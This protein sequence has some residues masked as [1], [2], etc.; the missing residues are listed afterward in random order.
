[1]LQRF[2]FIAACTLGISACHLGT[3]APPQDATKFL[4]GQDAGVAMRYFG[5]PMHGSPPSNQGAQL[6]WQNSR[7]VSSPAGKLLPAYEPQTLDDNGAAK[8]PR[9]ISYPP[10]TIVLRRCDVFLETDAQF[11]TTHVL[12]QN[13]QAD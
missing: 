8:P 11:I 9:L 7:V 2:L 12:L 5:H 3:S 10:N 4:L 1:M 13:C 6:S